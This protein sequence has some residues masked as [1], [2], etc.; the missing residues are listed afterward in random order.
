MSIG[1]EAGWAPEL[2]KTNYLKNLTT[3]SYPLLMLQE[4][5]E[6]ISALVVTELI[7]VLTVSPSH[8]KDYCPR[9][10]P[11]VQYYH[12]LIHRYSFMKLIFM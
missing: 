10:K 5:V 7:E 6:I 8:M 4:T 2:V 12:Q 3:I 9:L 1:Q 11:V